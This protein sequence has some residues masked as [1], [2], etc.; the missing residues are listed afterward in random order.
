MGEQNNPGIEQPNADAN[1]PDTGAETVDVAA[2]TAERD[3][4]LHFARQHEDKWKALSAE[5]DAVKQSQ[6]S[7]TDRAIEAA[8]AEARK[9]TL[10]EVG[11]K[12]TVAELTARAAKAGVTLPDPK[13]INLAALMGGDGEPD[14][15]AIDGFI[16]T[17][18]KPST[19]PA[20]A[21]E[22]LN[23]AGN[24]EANKPRQLTRADLQTMSYDEI[25]KA[26]KA[27]QLNDLLGIM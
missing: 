2:L 18:P 16:G 27:G 20:F 5:L 1:K 4:W 19:A 9:A 21:Q 25:E 3:K 23:N 8:K 6:M 10:S 14:G 24:R 11:G 12:L 22:V 7:D 15:D 26:R 17:L 13:F